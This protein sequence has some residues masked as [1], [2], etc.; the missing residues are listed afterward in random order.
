MFDRVLNTPL[1]TNEEKKNLS[2]LK[3]L[4]TPNFKRRNETKTEKD[5]NKNQL[6]KKYFCE[7]SVIIL[8]WWK[9]GSFWPVQQKIKLLS[10]YNL[11]QRRAITWCQGHFHTRTNYPLNQRKMIFWFN[12]EKNNLKDIAN[13]LCVLINKITKIK[14]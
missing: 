13:Y 14:Y 1:H 4:K 6:W 11:V 3:T 2:L 8:I 5:H 12:C 7:I 10:H 9:L